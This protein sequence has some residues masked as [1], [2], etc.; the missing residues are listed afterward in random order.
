MRNNNVS[1]P[2]KP[3]SPA[4]LGGYG[5]FGIGGT[6]GSGK[7]HLTG[8][9]Y[10]DKPILFIDL[11]GG[12]ETF[13]SPNFLNDPNAMPND[14]IHVI[15]FEH[16]VKPDQ[17]I[18]PHDLMQLV[19]RTLHYVIRTKNSDGYQAVVIDSLTELQNKFIA[20]H[21]AKDPRQAYGELKDSFYTMANYIRQ[22]PTHVFCLSGLK[23]TFDDE[24]Q[25][26]LIRMNI[27]PATWGVI[28]HA[29]SAIGYM[30]AV[31]RG[32]KVQRVCDFS[33]SSV[34]HTKDRYTIGEVKDPNLIALMESAKGA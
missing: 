23:H 32:V 34:Y 30:H 16:L 27:A 4:D 9:G 1:L 33:L 22:V 24:Q 3:R 12:S 6:A 11:E 2:V 15:G 8:T 13:N 29:F 14:M 31:K 20:N 28:S 25:K 10:K 18:P 5:K 26:E 7:T 21:P 19:L 17:T